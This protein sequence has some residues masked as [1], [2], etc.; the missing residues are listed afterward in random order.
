MT[1]KSGD[2]L[3]I[4]CLIDALAVLEE[5]EAASRKLRARLEPILNRLYCRWRSEHDE[6]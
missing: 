5:Q 1:Q 4:D 3:L 2:E 6:A